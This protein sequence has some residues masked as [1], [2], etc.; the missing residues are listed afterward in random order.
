[1]TVFCGM[2]AVVQVV[3]AGSPRIFNPAAAEWYDANVKSNY[4]IV[5]NKD[6]VPSLPSEIFG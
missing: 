4:R 1:M 5:N 3:T 2:Q 6:I